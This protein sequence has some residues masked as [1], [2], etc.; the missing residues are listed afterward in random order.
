MEF[1]GM[2]KPRANVVKQLVVVCDSQ[3]ILHVLMFM[4]VESKGLVWKIGATG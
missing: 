1:G 2:T 4:C 3:Q